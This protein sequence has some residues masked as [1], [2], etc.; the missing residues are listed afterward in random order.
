LSTKYQEALADKIGFELGW[1]EWIEPDSLLID[2]GQRR[3]TAKSFLKR[4]YEENLPKP[5]PRASAALV[6]LKEDMWAETSDM[7]TPLASL[8]LRTG[9]SQNAPGE[10]TLGF[11]LNCPQ[12]TAD[13]LITGVKRAVLIFDCGKGRTSD[14][15]ERTGYPGGETFNG[16]KFTPLSVDEG[17]PSWL[18]E[19]SGE[20]VIGLVGDAPAAFIRVLNLTPESSVGAIVKA[21]VK[22]IA[23][24]FVMPEGH[25]QSVAK[26]KIKNRLRGM[27]IA[28]GEMGEA[29]I[30]SAEI[31]FT[32]RET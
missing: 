9:Q 1:P 31:K 24:T 18:A 17:K 7:E 21:C 12:V 32:K 20:S 25:E 11:D 4:C 28:G 6:P 5:K 22:D 19:A 13:G 14:V 10:M 27:R 8:R 29:A 3:D 15:Q 23:T 30:A 16:V 26:Q 2:S